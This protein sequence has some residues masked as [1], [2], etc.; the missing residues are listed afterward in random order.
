MRTF[1]AWSILIAILCTTGTAA[2]GQA[3]GKAPATR[4]WNDGLYRSY[5]AFQA[6]RPDLSWDEVRGDWFHNPESGVTTIAALSDKTGASLP[7]SAF[8]G[9]CVDGKPALRV[10]VDSTKRSSSVFVRLEPFGAVSYFSYEGVVRD[11]IEIAA[12][13]PVTGQ[14]FRKGK[15]PRSAKEQRERILL[16]K[17]GEILPF[18]LP[19]VSAWLAGDAELRRALGQL[20]EPERDKMLKA[21][22]VFNQRNPL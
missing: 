13:N 16:F 19:S 6:N 7:P 2:V 9:L 8:W 15:V 18:D 17:T 14:P 12:Y 1:S 22:E 10:P 11:T 4:R 5:A 20:R 21:I 3:R